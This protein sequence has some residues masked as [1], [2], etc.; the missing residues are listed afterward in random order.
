MGLS[1]VAEELCLVPHWNTGI[2]Y[3]L[4]VWLA[5]SVLQ[6]FGVNW[7]SDPFLS[8]SQCSG[9]SIFV[10]FMLCPEG[11]LE[12]APLSSTLEV[13]L[14]PFTLN[15]VPQKYFCVLGSRSRSC[16]CWCKT[17]RASLLSIAQFVKA[18]PVARSVWRAVVW[19]VEQV[20]PLL[21]PLMTATILFLIVRSS[22]CLWP[23]H[24]YSNPLPTF[25]FF[26]EFINVAVFTLIYF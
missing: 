20:V 10:G 13:P 3:V 19:W 1:T 12:A 4:W 24:V 16:L 26:I 18:R 7:N 6:Q 2:L 25:N 15:W 11:T 23:K 5:L 14:I 21:S 8:S 22:A 17:T 9:V